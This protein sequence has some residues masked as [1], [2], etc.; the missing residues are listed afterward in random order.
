M[1][2]K[3]LSIVIG[4]EITKVCEVSYQKKNSPKNIRV[5]KS[6]SFHTPDHTIEDGMIKN[7][8]VFKES[9][10]HYLRAN[11]MKT[12]K[13]IFSI[14]S[15]KIA[16][17]EVIIP[18]VKESRI[19]DIVHAGAT[20]YF[21]VDIKEYILSYIVLEK[22]TS[23]RK[24]KALEKKLGKEQEKLNKKQARLEKKVSRKKKSRLIH[25][26]VSVS[27]SFNPDSGEDRKSRNDS[28]KDKNSSKKHIRLAVYAAPNAL[29]KNYYEFADE[30]GMDIVALDYSGNSGYQMIKRHAN[31]GTNVFVQLNDQ[32]TVISIL[33]DNVLI[34]QRTVGYGIST[35]LETVQEQPYY[36]VNTEKD[37]MNLLIN[38]NLL[39]QE[40]PEVIRF[41]A[42]WSMGEVA[43]AS[44]FIRSDVKNVFEEG[45]ENEARRYIVESLHI[46]TNSIARILD[47]YKTNNKTA[48][49]EAIYL[50]GMGVQIKGIDLFFTRE[51]GIENRRIEKLT[52]VSSKKMAISY[53]TNPSEYMSCVGAVIHPVDFIPMELILRKRRIRAVLGATCLLTVS[54]AGSAVLSYFGYLDYQDA[55]KE[56]SQVKA[57]L[58]AMPSVTDLYGEY[59]GIKQEVSQLQI[60]E[61]MTG[62]NNDNIN[63]VISEL[64]KKLLT[65]TVIHSMQF[66]NTG[67]AMSVTVNSD[68]WGANAIVAKMLIQLKSISYFQT[69]DI[70]DISEGVNEEMSGVSFSIHCTYDQPVN[71]P[72]PA[73]EN[74]DQ[75]QNGN[76]PDQADQIAE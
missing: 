71:P 33:R 28:A 15:S 6:I 9:L 24:E 45:K 32:D 67:V 74:G 17:R 31:Q 19:M 58:D 8:S 54:I 68:Q 5:Y 63:E 14:A 26:S 41:D 49:I 44:E 7:Q 13:V 30:M 60:L 22:R 56:Y 57:K 65:G 3:V 52:T 62:N 25:D 55:K 46:L 1:A 40:Q 21:P 64:E 76:M 23:D 75:T 66:T 51:I 73:A 27:S 59:D 18:P 69:V 61:D 20:D 42:S 12:K 50:S 11:K 10:K 35:F 47:Y 34:L 2:K 72:A 29:V 16:N 48:E 37:A 43:A 70:T 4:T 39:T 36:R 53:R 38:R